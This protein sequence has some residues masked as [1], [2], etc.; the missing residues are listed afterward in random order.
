MLP[1]G[2]DLGRELLLGKDNSSTKGRRSDNLQL[3]IAHSTLLEAAPNPNPSSKHTPTPLEAITIP[4]LQS[5]LLRLLN[6]LSTLQST[7]LRLLKLY[8]LSLFKALF[9][10][11]EA[12]T[13]IN[14]LETSLIA[15]CG[16]QIGGNKTTILQ[17]DVDQTNHSLSKPIGDDP[18]L[19]RL[20]YA[21]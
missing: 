10:P 5:T 13:I 18:S 16:L 14:Y 11:L 4:R 8:Q 6:N 3:F 15:S 1:I 12:A 21:S 2:G 19:Q 9:T 7:L 17:K 20:L